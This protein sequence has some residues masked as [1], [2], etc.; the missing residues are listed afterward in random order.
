MHR[1]LAMACTLVVF[2]ASTAHAD[3]A[4]RVLVL[5]TGD[6]ETAK[7]IRGQTQDLNVTL[8]FATRP[9]PIDAVSARSEAQHAAA[10]A[11]VWTESTA[12]RALT[13]HVLDVES[14]ALHQREIP[15]STRD[16]L[17]QSAGAEMAALVVRGELSALL[18]ERETRAHTKPKTN[19][20]DVVEAPETTQRPAARTSTV[21]LPTRPSSA[22]RA[23]LPL[24]KPWHAALGYR[25]SLPI[26]ETV[27]HALAL[28]VRRDVHR[29][30][31]GASAHAAWPLTLANDAARVRVFRAGLRLEAL[32]SVLLT[33]RFE[34][35]IGANAG[36]T[37]HTRTTKRV[38]SSLQ[39][40]DGS[41]SV[42]GALGLLAELQARLSEHVGVSAAAGLEGVLWRTKF[43][44]QSAAGERRVAA[45]KMA[46]PWMILGFFARW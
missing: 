17:A 3:A 7:R 22:P 24:K 44:Y 8:L 31:L 2:V 4:L 25:P 33:Q 46:E 18:S 16:A 10:Q 32:R 13:V 19:T 15:L 5:Q 1:L 45:L 27:A 23:L 42:S 41:T 36:F 43:T 40:N 20:R 12:P 39:A 28:T 26:R 21:R 34:L 14:G 11:V 29:F 30:A 9:P 35:L 6:G 38:S 37:L